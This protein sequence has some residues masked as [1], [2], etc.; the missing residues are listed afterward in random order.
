MATNDDG[1]TP[2]PVEDDRQFTTRAW[3]ILVVWT[4]GVVLIGS[5]MGL[6]SFML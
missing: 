5:L 3:L 1:T 4:V 6:L 2:L